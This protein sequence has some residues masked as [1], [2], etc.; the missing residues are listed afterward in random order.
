MSDRDLSFQAAVP[1]VR[2]IRAVEVFRNAAVSESLPDS[3]EKWGP[4][5]RFSTT[6][7]IIQTAPTGSKPS[8][9]KGQLWGDEMGGSMPMIPRQPLLKQETKTVL[10]L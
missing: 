9:A 5:C 1:V 2:K 7:G 4:K 8:P 3:T 10:V 6:I